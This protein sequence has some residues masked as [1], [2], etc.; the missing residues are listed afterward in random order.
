MNSI[1]LIEFFFFK[2]NNFNKYL[3]IIKK[4]YFLFVLDLIV[5]INNLT[6]FINLK[7]FI[8]L[9]LN[10]LY[11]EFYEFN[12]N[13]IMMMVA[14]SLEFFVGPTIPTFIHRIIVKDF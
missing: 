11:F 9:D 7:K 1:I 13:F 5:G 10:F 6:Y 12:F 2:I 14:G 4:N 3:I 8:I